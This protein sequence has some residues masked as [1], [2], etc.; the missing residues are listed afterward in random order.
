[1]HTF[2]LPHLTTP[3]QTKKWFKSH[4]YKQQVRRVQSDTLAIEGERLDALLR[5]ARYQR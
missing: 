4:V 2:T 3:Q 5:W 1:M